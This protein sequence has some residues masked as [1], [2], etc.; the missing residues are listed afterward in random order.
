MMVLWGGTGGENQSFDSGDEDEG[1]IN[2]DA[3]ASNPWGE[4]EDW[5]PCIVGNAWR[6]PPG[7]S[8]EGPSAYSLASLAY[9]RVCERCLS[10][11]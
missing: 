8:P 3:K 9:L 5:P 6:G 10:F 4:C 7:K 11:S 1:P 2:G